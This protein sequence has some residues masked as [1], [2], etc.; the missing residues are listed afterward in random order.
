MVGLNSHRTSNLLHKKN[1]NASHLLFVGKKVIQLE[2]E[3]YEP[4][5]LKEMMKLADHARTL[6]P[7]IYHIA[8]R[9]RI[10]V[11]PVRESSILIAVS[12]PHRRDAIA[13]CEW[14]IDELKATVPVWKKEH[15]ADGSV[16][17]VSENNERATTAS[18]RCKELK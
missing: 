11:V 9:H 18:G 8:M 15:Y 16:W 3:A 2:Y 6:W 4:M 12:S 10:G 5:A 1:S 14:L 13:A 17:K 7:D